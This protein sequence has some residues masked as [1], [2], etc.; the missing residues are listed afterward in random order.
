MKKRIVF[1]ADMQCGSRVGLTPPKWQYSKPDKYSV[2]REELWNQYTSILD[3][4]KPI[5]CYCHNGDAIE[6]SGWKQGSTDVLT[7]DRLEQVEMATEAIKYTE[8]KHI[9]LTRGTFY[10]VGSKENW[11]DILA[12]KV[13]AR[14]ISDEEF[15]NINGLLFNVKHTI[16]RANVPHTKGYHI[17]KARLWQILWSLKGQQPLCPIV[18]RAHVHYFFFCGEDNWLGINQPAL[19]GLGSKYGGRIPSETVDWG[20]IWFDVEDENNWSWDRHIVL[21]ETQKATPLEL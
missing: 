19:C 6:G 8:A 14:K 5:H 12:Q 9:V 2:I 3:E 7:T 20:L 17:S 1:G 4:L 11:E 18:L 13:K 16:S 15:I 10:H 21:G